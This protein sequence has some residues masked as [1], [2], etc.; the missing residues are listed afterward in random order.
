[1]RTAIRCAKPVCPPTPR[2]WGGGGTPQQASVSAEHQRLEGKNQRLKPQN[3]RMHEREGIDGVKKRSSHRAGIG[4]DDHVM[5][6]GIS[7]GNAAAAQSYA[8]E[9]AFVQRLERRDERAGPCH[10]LRID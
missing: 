1:M 7:V 5:V 2:E 8:V 3:Y 6:A 10:L 4:C 9:P